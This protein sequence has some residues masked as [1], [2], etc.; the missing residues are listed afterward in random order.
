[1]D[2]YLKH[3]RRPS[4]TTQNQKGGSSISPKSGEGNETNKINSSNPH[5]ITE[6]PVLFLD[7][8]FGNDK[9]TRIVMYKGKKNI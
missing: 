2:E 3:K 9:L 7:V 4:D 1:M 8:N 5:E 6:T